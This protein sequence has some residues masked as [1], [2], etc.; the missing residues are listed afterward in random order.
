MGSNLRLRWEYLPGSE[1]FVVDTDDYDTESDPQ[2]TAL[3]NHALCHQGDTPV[4]TL[5]GLRQGNR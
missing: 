4:S 3:R 2:S 1:L 5:T